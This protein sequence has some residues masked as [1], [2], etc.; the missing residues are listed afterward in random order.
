ME[1][2]LFTPHQGQ[3]KVIDGFADSPHKFGI[4]STGRQFGKSL[5]GQNLLLYWLLSTG[6]QKGAWISPIYNQAKKVFNEL[7]GASHSLIQ[8][9]NKADLT[10]KFLNGSTLQFL[11]AERPDSIRGFSFHY[12]VIDEAAYVK[13]NAILEAILP[14]LTA[15]G[16]KCLMIS[17]PAAKNHFYKY[18]LKGIDQ[19]GDYASFSGKSTDN[20]FIDEQFIEEQRVSLPAEIFAQEYLA[21]FSDAT[22]QVFKGLDNVCVVNQ[23]EQPNKAKRYFAGIDT[24]LSNDWSVLT[25]FEETG[26]LV[27]LKRLKGENIQAIASQFT[28][29]LSRYNIN[30][31]YIETNGIGK[32]MFDLIN[33]RIRKMRPFTTTQDSKTQIVRLLIEDIQNQVVELSSRELEPEL[34]RELSLYTYKLNTNGKLSFSHPAGMND[35]IVDSLMLA[36]KARNEIQTNSIYIGKPTFGSNHRSRIM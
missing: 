21:E 6:N 36:N 35:D 31:G 25:I 1:V 23:Y 24:G 17:T 30:G 26:R 34:Y 10:I 11:S 28:D 8:E 18:Y 29:V 9:K 13:E 12:L 16:K 20:P 19:S 2:T 5:L 14:T 22:S 15:L 4:V 7:V 33:P 3:K 32:A 27:F